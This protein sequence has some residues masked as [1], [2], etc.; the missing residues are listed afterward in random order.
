MV[1]V[2]WFFVLMCTSFHLMLK[3]VHDSGL[4]DVSNHIIYHRTVHNL[5]DIFDCAIKRSSLYEICHRCTFFFFGF[6][7]DGDERQFCLIPTVIICIL[8]KENFVISGRCNVLH[9]KFTAD[10]RR[11]LFCN[12]FL[13]F[14]ETQG[15]N[16]I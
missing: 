4:T 15:I 6:L 2:F 1:F 10:I 8:T 9:L 14:S 13:C 5:F 12:C 7:I 16:H 11:H 3:D